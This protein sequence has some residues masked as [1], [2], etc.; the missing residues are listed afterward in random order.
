M[1][2]ND[3]H[4]RAFLIWLAIYPLITVLFL[5]MGEFL[6]RYPLVI[7]TF[8]LT[9]VAVP[10]VFYVILPFYNRIFK[11]WLNHNK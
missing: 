8:I 2:A 7:R 5:L 11:Q 6:S 10:I 4:K 9:A 1:N 3:K